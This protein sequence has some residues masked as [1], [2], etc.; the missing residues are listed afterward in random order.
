M[1]QAKYLGPPLNSRLTF[2]KHIECIYKRAN[3][4]LA[5]I[6]LEEILISATEELEQ[7]PIV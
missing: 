7:M 3:S 5:L 4:A 6:L 1:H 2:I